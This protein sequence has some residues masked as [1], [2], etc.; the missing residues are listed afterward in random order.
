MTADG[1]GA[2]LDG[3]VLRLST[4]GRI[5]LR[6]HR[7]LQGTPKTVTLSNEADGW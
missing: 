2:V 7:P 3:G 5:A 1:G 4:L 6:L